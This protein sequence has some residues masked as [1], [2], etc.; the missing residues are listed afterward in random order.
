MLLQQQPWER[1]PIAYA[2]KKKRRVK[3]VAGDHEPAPT[4]TRAC[5]ESIRGLEWCNS[6]DEEFD[7][8]TK[9]GVVK[10][11]FIMAEIR[12]LGITSPVLPII[13]IYDCEYDKTGIINRLKTRAALQGDKWHMK[14]GVHYWE[15]FTATPRE[16]VSRTLAALLVHKNLKRR[17]GDIVKAYFWADLPKEQWLACKYPDGLQRV[18]EAGEELYCIVVTLFVRWTSKWSKLGHFA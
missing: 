4:N 6:I 8:L 11:G 16:D 9:M 15:T 17:C 1:H 18:N 10:N 3:A 7:G 13:L 2:V 5:L 14:K 12:A